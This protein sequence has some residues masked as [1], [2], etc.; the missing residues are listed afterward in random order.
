[1]L[2]TVL[3]ILLF[4]ANTITEHNYQEIILKKDYLSDKAQ[5]IVFF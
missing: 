3:F 1:M 2:I 4:L 5:I